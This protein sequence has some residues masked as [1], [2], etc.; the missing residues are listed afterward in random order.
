VALAACH[1]AP[2]PALLP[3]ALRLCQEQ[4]WDDAAVPLKEYLMQRPGDAAAHFYLGRCYLNGITL[5]PLAAEGEFEAALML[6]AQNGRKSPIAEY[7]DQYFEMRCRLEIAKVYL[8]MLRI[9]EEH[10]DITLRRR[11]L[12]D[13]RSKAADA[14]KVDPDAEEVKELERILD[15][16]ASAHPPHKPDMTAPSMAI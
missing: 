12:D 15:E 1:H 8:R 3:E 4:K 10:G 7:S 11:I 5:Y 2:N 9:A 6:F 14:K 13:C 16:V